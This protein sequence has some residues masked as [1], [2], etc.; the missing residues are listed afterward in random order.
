MNLATL[1]WFCADVSIE[2]D[3][4]HL[5]TYFYFCFRMMTLVL[6][7]LML[8]VKLIQT[9]LTQTQTGAL[10]RLKTLLEPVN[11]VSNYGSMMTAPK[12]EIDK[13]INNVV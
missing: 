8:D 4:L 10:I 13:M 6:E 3:I 7:H 9:I 5:Y 11:H 12:Y 2:I 1:E